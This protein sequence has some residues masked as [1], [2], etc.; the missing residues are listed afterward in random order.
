MIQRSTKSMKSMLNDEVI[1]LKHDDVTVLRVTKY[2][3]SAQ[4]MI[5]F[6]INLP[7][8]Q[9][10]SFSNHNDSYPLTMYHKLYIIRSSNNLK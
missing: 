10:Q 7:L 4:I 9:I 6:C 3:I 2:L 8:N 5:H 1:V